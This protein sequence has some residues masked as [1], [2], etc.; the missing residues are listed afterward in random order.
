MS[1]E[2]GTKHP[3]LRLCSSFTQL[4]HAS[5]QAPHQPG[6]HRD[7]RGSPHPTERSDVLGHAA[8]GPAAC[9]AA[10]LRPAPADKA[11]ACGRSPGRLHLHERQLEPP[12]S[13]ARILFAKY[14]FPRLV[15]QPQEQTAQRDP[16]ITLTGPKSPRP[17]A[18]GDLAHRSCT[19]HGGFFPE[20][21]ISAPR[22]RDFAAM[23]CSF[24]RGNN[25]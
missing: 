22:Y 16:Q 25:K 20:P 23:K 18:R 4:L 24:R 21:P 7:S 2:A 9:P 1:P 17:G 10:G 14:P 6:L 11:S 13:I 15:L 3:W 19:A 12:A 8:P 5:P